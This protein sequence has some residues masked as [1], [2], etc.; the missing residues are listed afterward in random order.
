M[1]VPAM[2]PAFL[3]GVP[4]EI[5]T[6]VEENTGVVTVNADDADVISLLD[7]EYAR[8]VLF[9]TYDQAWAADDLAERLD[10]APSTVYDRLSQLTDH[11]LVVEQQQINL[12]GYHH[13]TYRARLDRVVVNLTADGFEVTTT[14]KPTDPADRLTDAFDQLR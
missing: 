4:A 10:A 3:Q 7:D 1:T 13:K 12:D 9:L 6:M 14:R 5:V 2:H 8:A 11:D